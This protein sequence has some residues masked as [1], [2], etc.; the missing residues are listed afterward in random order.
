[1]PI[2]TASAASVTSATGFTVALLVAGALLTGCSSGGSG[3]ADASTPVA[4]QQPVVGLGS[5]EQVAAYLE[6]RISTMST[7]TVYTAATDPEHLLGK[8]DGY[9][10]KI[11]FTDSRVPPGSVSG[12]DPSPVDLGGVIETFS[13]P[14][15][16]RARASHLQAS[17]QGLD[18][19]EYHFYVGASL[20]RVSRILTPDQTQDYQDAAA[21]LG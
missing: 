5:A 2:R 18:A 20:V 19:A 3:T 6:Q 9:R 10:S 13:T 15:E 11:A 17:L 8:R 16:A 1:M 14:S 7:T 12:T 21:S 4:E